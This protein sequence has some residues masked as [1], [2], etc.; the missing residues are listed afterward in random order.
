MKNKAYVKEL[1]GGKA[2]L[3][4]KRECACGGKDNC[5]IKCFYLQSDIMEVSVENDV[6]A[7]EG[8]YVE[9]EGKTPAILLYSAAA[10]ILP[11]IIG[12]ILYFTADNLCKNSE[13]EILPYIVAGIGF[14]TSVV[15]L[16]FFL[17]NTAK[18][19]NDF[20]ITKIL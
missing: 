3:K 10:F 20:K 6:G 13:N 5:N 15:F 2:V 4:I 9:V 12:I 16:Y 19:R 1:T 11:V 8:D 7:K 14:V 17:D 18:N